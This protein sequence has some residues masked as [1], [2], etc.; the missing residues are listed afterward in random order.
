MTVE[1]KQEL[2]QDLI[3]WMDRFDT[4]GIM[5]SSIQSKLFPFSPGPNRYAKGT[6]IYE[7]ILPNTNIQKIVLAHENN[8]VKPF[9]LELDVQ[10]KR[11]L[12]A[13]V[14]ICADT[15]CASLFDGDNILAKIDSE[16]LEIKMLEALYNLFTDQPNSQQSPSPQSSDTTS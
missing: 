11:V 13:E 14:N 12:T 15:E 10:G 2:K 5:E 3:R 4:Q 6:V 1:N 7:H 16:E 9:V 8:E